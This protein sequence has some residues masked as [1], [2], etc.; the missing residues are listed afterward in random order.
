MRSKPI[1]TY[2]LTDRQTILDYVW[3][4]FLIE[5]N[6]P[7][8]AEGRETCLY[9]TPTGGCAVGCLL[10]AARRE[11]LHDNQCGISHMMTYLNPV[12]TDLF[13]AEL[14]DFL[15]QLQVTHDGAAMVE[16]DAS[17]LRPLAEFRVR[18]AAD[19]RRLAKE[20]HLEPTVP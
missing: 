17:R 19:L 14:R 9:D 16:Y 20:Y 6:P 15:T 13:T 11:A 1:L 2:P 5:G 7:G 8:A 10:P 3:H 12:V 18:F 4:H